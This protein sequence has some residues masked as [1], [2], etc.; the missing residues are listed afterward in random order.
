MINTSEIRQFWMDKNGTGLSPWDMAHWSCAERLLGRLVDEVAIPDEAARERE[1]KFSDYTPE[2]GAALADGLHRD[3]ASKALA[4]RWCERLMRYCEVRRFGLVR[5]SIELWEG[6]HAAEN[7]LLSIAAL[8]AEASGATGDAR[9]LNTALKLL[10]RCQKAVAARFAGS[11]R[12]GAAIATHALLAAERA[13]RKV[14]MAV[15]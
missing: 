1:P 7:A 14:G 13:R 3:A 4:T 5:R 11:G 10:A 9:Y 15:D 8:L 6:K 2:L 12:P